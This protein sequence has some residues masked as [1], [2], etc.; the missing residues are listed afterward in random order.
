MMPGT[1]PRRPHP[2]QDVDSAPFWQGL[3]EHR[4]MIQ[5]CRGCGRRRFPPRPFCPNRCAA[6]TAWVSCSH[7]GVLVSWVITHRA[8]H[9]AFA[10]L[11]PY[12]VLLVQFAD[13]PD[14]LVYGN[15][16]GELPRLRPGLPLQAVFDDVDTELT[17]LQ[18]QA[19]DQGNGP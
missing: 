6:E 2:P 8:L 4:I 11:V 3:R 15:F 14:L 19:R 7:T 12:A 5:S 16:V 18:W 9:P 10:R 13:R 1:G 17:L